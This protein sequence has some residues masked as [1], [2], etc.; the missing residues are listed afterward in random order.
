MKT[1]NK[2]AKKLR[3]LEKIPSGISGLDEITG[4][5][6]PKGRPT[7]VCGS[8]GCGK[9]L[10]AMEFLVRGA[11]E[12]NDPGVFMAFEENEEE[13]TRNVASLGF[14]LNALRARKKIVLHHVRVERS[15]IEET[16]EYDL[17]GLF[18]RLN[19][20]IDSIGAKRVVLDTIEVL[21]AALPNENILRSELRRLFRWLKDKGVSAI[22]T[23]EGGGDSGSLTRHG[24]EEYV[25][26]C[27][28]LLD[29]RVNEQL[30]TRRL[31]VVKYRG[32]VHGTNEYPFLISKDGFSVLPV[33]SMGLDH[34]ASGERI[35]SGV[36]RLDTMLS[37]QGYYRGSS[38]LVSGTAGTGKSSIAA[39]FVDAA[40]RR[41]ER[42]LYF[43]FEE[44]QNQILRNMRSIGLNLEPWVKKGLLQ[45]HASRPSLCGLE[46]HLL[47]IYEAVKKFK[48]RVVVMDPVTNL[49]SVGT[50]IEVRSMLTRLIDFFKTEQVTALF[51][52]LTTG[53]SSQS[54]VAISSLMDV[55]VLLRNIESGGE[56]NRGLYILKSR[57]MEHSNQI[58]E[59][60]LSHLGIGLVDVYAGPAT[61]LTGSA[62]IEQEGREKAEGDRR[63]VQMDRRQREIER[64]RG[65]T[66]AKVAVLRAGLEAKI[67][68]LNQEITE[69]TL[70]DQVNAKS[71]FSLAANR[72]AD[73]QP[74]SLGNGT[75]RIQETTE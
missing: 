15:E 31:R 50:E 53:D 35:S 74:K 43:A 2:K 57:G 47:T 59:V 62:R 5:G 23:A 42:A 37:G 56:R 14:D 19:H 17:E 20:A 18:I 16:G 66:D 30:S 26:D 46:M 55:C 63:K 27:V 13:L 67:E 7:L 12:H 28:I 40:C 75:N 73:A 68:E 22:I 51:P 3:A 45:F 65:V 48:P 49:V 38:I 69:E 44:S 72:Q 6:L 39:A 9:T 60:L 4:G 33:T 70:I 36:E 25:A 52:G 34:P 1:E 64:E 8:A 11:V 71:R 10:M 32:S 29:H 24:L 58:R 54:E 21:F 41:G 61:V